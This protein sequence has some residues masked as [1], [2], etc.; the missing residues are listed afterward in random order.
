[1]QV[2][3]YLQVKMVE[4]MNC[5]KHSDH[6]TNILHCLCFYFKLVIQLCQLVLIVLKQIKINFETWGR[7]GGVVYISKKQEVWC[8]VRI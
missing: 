8:V 2:F 4:T 1:M 7:E 6:I 5:G 3:F